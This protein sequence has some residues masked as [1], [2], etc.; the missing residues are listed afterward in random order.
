MIAMKDNPILECV[1]LTKDYGAMTALDNVNL[2]IGRGKIVGILGPN[3][4]GKTTLIKLANGLLKPTDGQILIDGQ[5]PGIRSKEIVSYLPD[6]EYFGRW[7]KVKDVLNL[8]TEFYSNFDRAK[9]L[10]MCETLRISEDMPVNSM[11]NGTL[12]KLQL[13]LVM[14][15]NAELYLLDEP[16]AGV[17]PAARDFILSTII[18]NYNEEGTIIISTHLI[19]DIERILDE[20]V[21][22]KDGR[23]VRHSTVDQ[24]REREGKS[25]DELFRTEFRMT[26][27]GEEEA[28]YDW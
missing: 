26:A 13:V 27:P 23:V 9:A 18:N 14:S 11:S 19:S 28:R 16:I 8:F 25:I 24:I 4:S 3:G 17:D 7:M 22:I 10:R 20:V 15:R 1:N 6:R 12:E 21:F 5:E 2:K